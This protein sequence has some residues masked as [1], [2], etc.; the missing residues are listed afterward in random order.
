VEF[1]CA[2][3]W[4]D[5]SSGF[6]QDKK[7]HHR[8]NFDYFWKNN[9]ENI[10]WFSQYLPVDKKKCKKHKRCSLSKKD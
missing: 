4:R 10:A 6:C 3:H 9:A 2:L 1:S 7:I 8:E 5:R